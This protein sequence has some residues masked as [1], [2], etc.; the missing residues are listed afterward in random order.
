MIDCDGTIN[1]KQ[2]NHAIHILRASVAGLLYCHPIAGE[3]WVLTVTPGARTVYLG[4]G[5][6]TTN[7]ANATINLVSVTVP[8]AV[9]GTGAAQA[10]TSNS[11]QA[12]SPFDNFTVCVPP[13]QVYIGGYFREPATTAN[14]ARLQVNTPATLTSGTDTLPF[15]QI[16]WTSTALGNATADIPAGTFNGATLFLRNITSNTF[17]ENCHTFTYANAN[18][19]AAGVYNGRATYTLASP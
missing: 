1:K 5:N 8:A 17:V 13:N 16:S 12:N 10:M 18:L 11:T 14:V 3:A 7:A 9:V 15:T 19:V 4:V 6:S 2:R